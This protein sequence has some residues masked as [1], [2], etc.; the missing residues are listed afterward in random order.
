MKKKQINMYVVYDSMGRKTEHYIAASNMTEAIKL[1]QNDPKITGSY[2]KLKR[3]YKT[4]KK[5]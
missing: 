3:V 4:G 2:W 1:S 5:T